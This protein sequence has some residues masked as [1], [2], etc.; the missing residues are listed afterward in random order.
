LVK[1]NFCP[2]TSTWPPFSLVWI[3]L[4]IP[5]TDDEIVNVVSVR[6][7]PDELVPTGLLLTELVTEIGSEVSV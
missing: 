4:L 1:L 2:S 3:A 5:D 7:K 6:A